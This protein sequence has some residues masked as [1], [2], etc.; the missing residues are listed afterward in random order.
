MGALEDDAH[1][2]DD[3]NDDADDC[4]CEVRRHYGPA[5]PRVWKRCP[6]TGHVSKLCQRV[7]VCR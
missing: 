6:W 4:A 2:D 7:A 3:N 5:V 1:Y